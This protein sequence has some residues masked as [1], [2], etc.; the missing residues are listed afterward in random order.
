MKLNTTFRTILVFSLSLILL[1]SCKKDNNPPQPDFA[2]A[3]NLNGA[4]DTFAL[5]YCWIQ[6]NG[7]DPT[8]TDF[9]VVARSAD[10]SQQFWLTIQVKGDFVPGVYTSGNSNYTVIADYIMNIGETSERDY[11]IDHALDNPESSFTV[12]ISSIKNN[13]IKGTFIGNYLYDR[14]YDEMINLTDG[15]FTVKKK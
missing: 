11:T 15:S 12:T 13:V 3:F 14:N 5:G 6:P 1:F 8:N 4:R 10:N 2:V 7:S 9:M